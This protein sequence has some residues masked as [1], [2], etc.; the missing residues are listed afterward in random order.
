MSAR[1]SR[2]SSAA[3]NASSATP[4]AFRT[5]D[6]RT[7]EIAIAVRSL[8][9]M[10]DL[11]L[12]RPRRVISTLGKGRPATDITSLQQSPSTASISS[13]HH[14]GRLFKCTPGCRGDTYPVEVLGRAEVPRLRIRALGSR[15]GRV[16]P[17]GRTGGN[18]N[19]NRMESYCI[20]EFI[21]GLTMDAGSLGGGNP[22]RLPVWRRASAGRRRAGGAGMP[23]RL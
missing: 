2:R 13:V 14:A 16:N 3:G 20:G 17:C 11:D 8:N 23:R 10:L 6:R 9:H 18:R 7:T 21:G 19:E 15:V 4:C 5:E 1:W 12:L 22:H